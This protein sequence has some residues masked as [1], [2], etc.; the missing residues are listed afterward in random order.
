[1][2]DNAL[3]APGCAAAQALDHTSEPLDSAQLVRIWRALSMQL[4]AMLQTRSPDQPWLDVALL[5]RIRQEASAVELSAFIRKL[6]GQ[7]RV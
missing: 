1:M 7:R 4:V 2:S 6:E 3:N 5:K